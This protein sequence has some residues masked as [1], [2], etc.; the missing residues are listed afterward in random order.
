LIASEPRAGFTPKSVLMTEGVNADFS[1]DNYTPPHSIEV[2]AVAMGLPPQ[3]PIIHP[4][5][6]LAWSSLEPVLIPPDGLSGNLAQ[7]LAS[8]VLAQWEAARASDGHFVIYDIPQAMA[9]AS[10]FVRNLMDDPK[11]RVPAP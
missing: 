11:G 7:G 9:Q 8:G 5:S 3:E 10:G 2:Q 1:G 6:E 4:I